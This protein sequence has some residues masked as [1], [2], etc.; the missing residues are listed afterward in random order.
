[1]NNPTVNV[2]VQKNRVKLYDGK[3]IFLQKGQEFEIE[4][5]NPTQDRIVAKIKVNGQDISND[6]SGIIINPGQRIYLERYLKSSNKFKFDT[7]TVEN[8]NA[9]V[10][11]AIANNGNIEVSF[12]KEYIAPK[13]IELHTPIIIKKS[14]I[15]IEEEP[16]IIRRSHPFNPWAYPYGYGTTGQ[17]FTASSGNSN[18]TANASYHCNTGGSNLY[19]ADTEIDYNLLNN[20]TADSLDFAPQSLSDDVKLSSKRRLSKSAL[21]E[22][23]ETGRISEGNYSSQN[24][25]N[26][27]MTFEPIAFHTVILKIYPVSQKDF[28]TEGD[29][30]IYCTACG[31]KKVKPQWKFCPK[32]GNKY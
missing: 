13:P 6:N 32:C 8:G 29:I 25:T 16:I 31:K 3:N 4:L 19:N 18:L 23:K 10:D 11:R 30:N 12:H 24:F 15:I 22:D 28:V 5:F 20:V 26:V 17:G 9:D 1:M 27:H 14:P 7:Y 21:N 2:T